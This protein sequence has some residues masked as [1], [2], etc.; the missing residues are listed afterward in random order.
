MCVCAC[1]SPDREGIWRC[2]WRA[3]EDLE[4]TLLRS[5]YSE[6]WRQAK[7][8]DSRSS[9]C[10]LQAHTIDI[11][12]IALTCNRLWYEAIGLPFRCTVVL[13]TII[14]HGSQSCELLCYYHARSSKC[15][16][17][18]RRGEKYQ[19]LWTLY[20]ATINW[21]G[22]ITWNRGGREVVLMAFNCCNFY[23]RPF[24]DDSKYSFPP[25]QPFPPHT[26]SS[27]SNFQSCDK[28]PSSHS[29]FL[30]KEVWWAITLQLPTEPKGPGHRIRHSVSAITSQTSLA[31]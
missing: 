19:H 21:L 18:R 26:V 22:L 20:T 2:V 28:A 14:D 12:C 4:C 13:A 24:I 15:L 23:P 27:S 6:K 11:N 3:R 9:G 16:C 5:A 17:V 1:F 7:R 31:P 8:W 29:S 25:H 30:W 10:A